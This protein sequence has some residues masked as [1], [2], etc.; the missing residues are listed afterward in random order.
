V[1]R[2]LPPG[3]TLEVSDAARVPPLVLR[4]DVAALVGV[5]ERGPLDTPLPV[6][7][8]RQFSSVYGG[9]IEGGY[10]AYAARAFFENGGRRLWVVRVGHRVFGIDELP[11]NC[12]QP[13]QLLLANLAGQPALRLAASSPGSWGNALSLQWSYSGQVVTHSLPAAS[14]PTATR[15]LSIAGFAASELVRIEQGAAVLHRVIAQAD[16]LTRTLHWVH[17]DP[18][19][20]RASD[21]PLFGV[22]PTQALRIVRIAYALVLRE[23]GQVVAS[24]SDLHLVAHHP[25][26]ITELLRA[27]SYFEQWLTEGNDFVPHPP[28]PLAASSLVTGAVPLPLAV[29]PGQALPLTGGADGLTDLVC[30]EFIG[31][32]ASPEDSDFVR[33]RKNRGARCLAQVDQIALLAMPDLLIRPAPLPDTLPLEQ[34][35]RD[36]CLDCPPAPPARAPHLPAPPAEVPGPYSNEDIARAQAALIA[37]A[38]AAGDRFVVLGAPL[39]LQESLQSRDQ[40]IAWRARFNTRIAALYAPWLR[41][42]DPRALV[43]VRATRLVPACGHVLGA[44]AATDLAEG[45]QRAPALRTLSGAVSLGRAIDDA[46]HAVWNDAGIN[47]LRIERAFGAQVAGA[48]TLFHELPFRYVNVVRLV[49]TIKK[50]CDIALRW[51]V[52]EPHDAELRE[53]VRTTLLSILRLFHARGAFAGDSEA[54][55]FYVLCDETTNPQDVRDAGRLMAEVGIAPAVPAEFIVLRVGRQSGSPQVELF[56]VEESQ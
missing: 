52:F 50:A 38:E 56:A 13:A 33:T 17:P 9:F 36:P 44:I 40:L 34:P 55:S 14:T 24:Y 51:T 19:R 25:R 47:A 54:T 4:T 3:V 30:D 26:C 11:P 20:R 43:G 18:Q 45:V 31:E 22:D 15:V 1:D 37:L 5:A 48:R 42:A 2:S 53:Q 28:P 16:A 10:L 12:A 6:E 35:P 49:L 46:T 27:P 21:Q 7:S 32:E 39:P 29:T 8:M 23:R 41:V